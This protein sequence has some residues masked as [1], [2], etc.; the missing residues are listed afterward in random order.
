MHNMDAT[1]A[2]AD[3]QCHSECDTELDSNASFVGPEIKM[4]DNGDAIQGNHS[5]QMDV[6]HL[7][8]K[9]QVGDGSSSF[10]ILVV[11]LTRP[12]SETDAL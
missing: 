12:S 3:Q 4:E 1:E 8:P 6:D 10:L 5:H 7:A 9:A 2:E 11:P